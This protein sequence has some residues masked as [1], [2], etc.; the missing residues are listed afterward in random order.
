MAHKSVR[1]S[2]LVLLM[3]GVLVGGLPSA[4]PLARADAPP[5]HFTT[6]GTVLWSQGDYLSQLHLATIVGNRIVADHLVFTGPL[7]YPF[8]DK[9]GDGVLSPDGHSVLLTVFRRFPFGDLALLD[10]TTRHLRLLTQ[11]GYYYYVSWSPDGR[12]FL[13]LSDNAHFDPAI[14]RDVEN[15]SQVTVFEAKTGNVCCQTN[16]VYAPIWARDS[17][18]IVFSRFPKYGLHMPPGIIWPENSTQPAPKWPRQFFAL[19]LTNKLRPISSREVDRKIG[20]AYRP[21]ISAYQEKNPGIAYSQNNPT[22]VGFSPN[23]KRA[24]LIT[25]TAHMDAVPSDVNTTYFLIDRHGIVSQ[26]RYQG[27]LEYWRWSPDGNLLYCAGEDTI[28]KNISMISSKTGHLTRLMLGSSWTNRRVMD[29][30]EQ[31]SR[32]SVTSKR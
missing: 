30:H 11:T 23:G 2:L 13:G 10:L 7:V 21:L 6:R 1:F 24:M 14:Y 31:A 12:Y 5:Q 4:V 28:G 15:K 17:K 19:S 32:S 16:Y 9:E 20:L 25:A 22:S 3:A 8:T 26:H 29:F 18:S 27:S